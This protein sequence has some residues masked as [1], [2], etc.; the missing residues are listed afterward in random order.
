MSTAVYD[1]LTNI[2]ATWICCNCGLP[3]FES[4]L[5]RNSN[6]E[7][8]N[9]FALLTDSGSDIG[10]PLAAPCPTHRQNNSCRSTK[11]GVIS[12]ISL[13]SL[14]KIAEFQEIVTRKNIDLILAC[15]TKL[16]VDQATYSFLRPNYI[17][18]RKD[19]NEHGG[20]VLLAHKDDFT[21]SQPTFVKHITGESVWTE[22]HSNTSK[23][24]T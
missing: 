11:R 3:N 10:S 22:V 12:C 7:T 9:S 21:L 4:S 13:K 24:P 14:G 20:G 23:S 19:R 6:I 15:E 1:A 8:S 2:S 18:Y 17:A 5:F 16:S